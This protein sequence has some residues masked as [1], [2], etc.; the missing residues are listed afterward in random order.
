M[1]EDQ[2]QAAFW[3]WAWNT[4][5]TARRLMWAVPNGLNLSI[6]HA[7]LA[8]ATGLLA[9]VWDLHLF[10]QGTLHIIE[11]KIGSNQLTVDRIVNGKK[12]YGQKEW[13]ELMAAHGAVRHI[14][15]TL[16]EGKKIFESIIFKK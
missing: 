16:D 7:Q 15:R 9:G 14:Y 1:S 2:L 8:K 6:Q 11:T 13:G 4:H 12:V 10:W 3:A 5:P